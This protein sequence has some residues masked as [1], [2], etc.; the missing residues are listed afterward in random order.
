MN[1]IL[2]PGFGF[3]VG[4]ALKATLILL[5]TALA[6]IALNR[7]GAAARHFVATAGL[8][9]ALVL[10]LLAV[11]LPHWEIPLLPSAAKEIHFWEPQSV[12][13]RSALNR[14][15][16]SGSAPRAREERAVSIAKTA[17]ATETAPA[18]RIPWF[19]LALA[20]WA[21]GAS[22]VVSRLVV[23]LARVRAIRREAAPLSDADWTDEVRKL[24]RRLVV[25]R[26]VEVYESTRVPVAVTSGLLRPFLLLGRQAR[27]WAAERRRIVLLH[28]LAHVKRG[29]WIWILL[30]ETALALYW[31][32]P[33]AWLLTAQVRRDGE[34][35]CDDLVLAAG[36]KP[37]AY[38]GH[39]LGIFRSLSVAAH[40]VAPALTSARPSHFEGR[41]R[42]ILDPANPPRQLPRTRAMLS[43]AG[44]IAAAV[45][46]AAIQPW[47]ATCAGASLDSVRKP[48]PAVAGRNARPADPPACPARAAESPARAVRAAADESSSASTALTPVETVPPAGLASPGRALPAVRKALDSM[49]EPVP[50]FIRASNDGP[51]AGERSG[52]DWFSR[53]MRLHEDEQ[54]DEAIQA[55]QKAIEAGYREDVAAYNIACGYALKGDRDRAFEWLRRAEAAGFDVSSHL[56]HDDDLDNLKSDPRW[57]ALKNEAHLRPSAR[58]EREAE[59]AVKR[60]ER[61]ASANP[62]SGEAYYEVGKQLLNAGRYELSARSFQAAA[63]HGYRVGTSLYNEA[64][65]LSRGGQ[66]RAALDMLQKALDAGF[67][68]PSLFRSDEDL[69]NLRDEPRFVELEREARELSLPG[70][71]IEIA[72][73]SAVQKVRDLTSSWNRSLW[74]EAAGKFED[75]AKAHPQKGRAWFNLGYASLQ[76]D[77]PDRAA[78]AFQ[79]ALDLNYR[80]PT[81][82]YNLACSYARLDQRDKAFD[83]LFQALSAGFD[84][85]G[86]LRGD[87]D[88]DNLRG[89]PRFRKALDIARSR[90]NDRDGH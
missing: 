47:A 81:T 28:E 90:E 76:A 80:R 56:G 18:R 14:E 75:C 5:I 33:L 60:Y 86:M 21:F 82:M 77:R 20:A 17:R 25:K 53:G 69:D 9:S 11:A 61:I 65:A 44:L 79:K 70:S 10:P 59:A 36:T 64:C 48:A 27:L 2:T 85:T 83:W 88:L 84:G 23:G 74:R 16:T 46:I 41:L 31:W 87:E 29:D 68:Q 38:A 58:R 3:A 57:K 32:H 26:P 7:S 63:D 51:G 89:D 4:V 1:E 37:S 40:P 62:K 78:E 71:G 30:A 24:A 19:P 73:R 67:D 50:G 34:K 12:P 54:Y 49:T 55:F 15:E 66:K 6:V 22:L 45:G 8:I 72:A 13:V 39:L 35:A 42:S 52:R 43:A